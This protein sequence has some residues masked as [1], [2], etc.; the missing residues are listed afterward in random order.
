[1]FI[2][3]SLLFC[4]SSHVPIKRMALTDTICGDKTCVLEYRLM[5][6]CIFYFD[7]SEQ[8]KCD[9]PCSKEHCLTE[10][11]F[12]VRCPVW[13]CM[14]TTTTPSPTPVPESG[15]SFCSGPGCIASFTINGLILL[16]VLIGVLVYRIRKRRQRR[17]QVLFDNGLFGT[18]FDSFVNETHNTPTLARSQSEGR[19]A[20]ERL[21]LLPLHNPVRPTTTAEPDFDTVDLGPPPTVVI[22]P[23]RM[24]HSAPILSPISE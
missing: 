22:K 17:E 14:S 13:S 15:S 20:T 18:S 3:P 4:C 10:H 7:E 19:V 9:F 12:W 23:S 16:V 8:L 11:H 24:S 5:E 21:P 2:D 6:N 1:M